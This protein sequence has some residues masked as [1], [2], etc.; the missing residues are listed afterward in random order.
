MIKTY[1]DIN[2][3]LIFF[4]RFFGRPMQQERKDIIT[5]VIAPIR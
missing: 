3:Y 5:S 2:R 4:D 1:R